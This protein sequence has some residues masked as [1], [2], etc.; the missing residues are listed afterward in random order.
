ML[1]RVAAIISWGPKILR[2][3]VVP[4]QNNLLGGSAGGFA[5]TVTATWLCCA[6]YQDR[7]HKQSLHFVG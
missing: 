6:R 4:V 5:V 3:S 7:I 1:F 2:F